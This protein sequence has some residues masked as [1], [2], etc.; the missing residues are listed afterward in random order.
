MLK[1]LLVLAG[2]AAASITMPSVASAQ[3]Y[4][5]GSVGPNNAKFN[6]DDYSFRDP[7]VAESQDR[8]VWGFKLY[9]GYEINRHLAI[10]AGYANLGSPEYRYE[11]GPFAGQAE[12]K[13]SA[14]FAALKGTLPLGE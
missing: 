11:V 5:G 8:N 4:I 2:F 13:Q 14:F 12:V 3:F 6:V 1:K 7:A 9:G 10:E